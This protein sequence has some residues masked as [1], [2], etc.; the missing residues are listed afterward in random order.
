M[1]RPSRIAAVVLAVGCAAALMVWVGRQRQ[2]QRVAVEARIPSI[3]GT[4][5]L[6]KAVVGAGD[7]ERGRRAIQAAEAAL[8]DVDARMSTWVGSTEL[9]KFNAAPANTAMPLSIPTLEVLAAAGRFAERTGGAF[10]PTC[11]PLLQL[12]KRCEQEDREPTADEIARTLARVGWRHIRLHD[13][14]MAKLVDGVEVDLGGL[15]KGYAVDAAVQAMRSAGAAGG[16]VQCGGDLRVFGDSEN[17][18]PWRIGIHDPSSTQSGMFAE[19]LRLADHAV[20]TSGDYERYFTIR[21]RRRSHIIDPRT[22]LPV[23]SVPQVTVVASEGIVSDGW[24]TAL[25]VL[26]PEGLRLLPPGVEAMVIVTSAGQARAHK[27][28]GFDRLLADSVP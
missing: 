13:G 22:G 1:S 18:G 8:R 5:T 14:A 12:W 23:D 19:R 9:S 7:Q 2:N 26:G 27:T 20:S 17:G 24:S 16:L 3:M 11:R 4:Q 25:T 10:D 21:G 28:P 15:A 6:L